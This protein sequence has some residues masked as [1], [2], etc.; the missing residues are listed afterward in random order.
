MSGD[1]ISGVASIIT[2]LQ[3]TIPHLIAA[4]HSLTPEGKVEE[5]VADMRASAAELSGCIN[6][7]LL[8]SGRIAEI[9]GKINA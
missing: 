9:N 8:D 6:T 7:G 2:L 1:P 5:I 4:M 3:Q